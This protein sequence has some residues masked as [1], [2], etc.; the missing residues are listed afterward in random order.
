VCAFESGNNRNVETKFIRPTVSCCQT[1]HSKRPRTASE[2]MLRHC[3]IAL[4]VL[5]AFATW[6][7]CENQPQVEDFAMDNSVKE[8]E[9][10]YAEAYDEQYENY[11]EEIDCPEAGDETRPSTTRRTTK[12]TRR[13]G[14]PT[15]SRTTRRFTRRPSRVRPT[16]IRPSYAGNFF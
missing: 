8:T 4:L 1:V 12:T 3:F 11:P 7:T 16:R 6:S 9:K 10:C 14:L 2:T 5:T 13:F 15:R